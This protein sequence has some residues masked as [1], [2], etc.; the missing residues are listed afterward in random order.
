MGEGSGPVDAREAPEWSQ[1]VDTHHGHVGLV[2]GHPL[3]EVEFEANFA[4]HLPSDPAA[5]ILEIGCGM[6]ATLRQLAARGYRDL[7][8]WDISRECVERA[9]E[10]GVPAR[11]EHLDAIEGARSGVA[12]RFDAILAKDLLEHLPREQV[13][14][15]TAGVHRLL[16]DGGV[17]VARLPNMGSPLATLLRYDDFTHTLGFTENSLRQVFGLGGFARDDVRVLADRLPAM[18]LLRRG[19]F[20]SCFREAVSGPTVRWLLR[21]ALRSQRKGAPRVDTLRLIVVARRRAAGPDS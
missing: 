4:A 1:Y 6:G 15:F 7:T 21:V 10:S 14:P 12:N 20:A 13:V 3:R 16:A 8:G 11:I 2:E 17:F 9:R 19:L 18:A 5:R